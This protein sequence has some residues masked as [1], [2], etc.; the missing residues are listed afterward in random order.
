MGFL[1]DVLG[2]IGG[3]QGQEGG[4]ASITKLFSANGGLQGVTAKLT[5][6][7]QG[8]QVQSWVGTGEN[9][10]VTGA[11]VKQ[12]LDDD[13]LNKMA[14]QA[15]TTPDK[16]SEDVAQVLPQMVSRATPQGEAPAQSDDPFSKGVDAIKGMFARN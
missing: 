5:S 11:D 15:G 8:Q 7:G 9:K 10:P 6:N 2:K 14:Q 13:S 4:L 16:V 1:D 12:A 3:Q